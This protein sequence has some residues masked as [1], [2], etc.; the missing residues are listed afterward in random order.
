MVHIHNLQVLRETHHQHIR[1]HESQIVLQN[2]GLSFAK[3]AEKICTMVY[4]AIPKSPTLKMTKKIHNIGK[5]THSLAS[6][7][8]AHH[9]RSCFNQF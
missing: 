4:Q 6:R 1:P 3:I 2:P 8:R 7:G 9:P 5:L